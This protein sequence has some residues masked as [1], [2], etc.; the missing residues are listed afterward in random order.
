M[1]TMQGTTLEVTPDRWIPV[2]AEFTRENRGAHGDLEI[3][4]GE[5]GRSVA[6]ED[7]PFDGISADVKDGE[8]TVWIMFGSEPEDRLTHSVQNVTAIR[9]RLPVGESGAAVEVDATDGSRT[10]LKL[11]LPQEYALPPAEK[12][13]LRKVIQHRARPRSRCLSTLARGAQRR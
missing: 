12:R 2:L 3:L 4:G 10:I 13:A 7:R 6:T 1:A 9:V 8:R 11:S 5:I